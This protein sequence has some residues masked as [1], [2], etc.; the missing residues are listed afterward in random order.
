ME[1][2]CSQTQFFQANAE[3]LHQIGHDCFFLKS[4]TIHHSPFVLPYDFVESSSKKT[5]LLKCVAKM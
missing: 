2:S 1:V 4:F 5:M 3:I